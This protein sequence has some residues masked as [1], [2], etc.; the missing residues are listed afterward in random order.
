MI[1][2]NGAGRRHCR[3]ALPV[4]KCFI[5]AP[6]LCFA[7]L[8]AIATLATAA[9]DTPWIAFFGDY[10]RREGQ[11]P[12][13]PTACCSAP[14]CWRCGAAS[15]WTGS[16]TCCC[17]RLPCCYVYAVMQRCNWAF[18]SKP[19]ACWSAPPARVP[20]APS[21]SVGLPGFAF[22]V[23]HSAH[24]GAGA[25]AGASA[26]ARGAAAQEVCQLV[27]GLNLCQLLEHE[28]FYRDPVAKPRPGTSVSPSPW[29]CSCC[30]WVPGG[31]PAADRR[32]AGRGTGARRRPPTAISLVPA[33]VRGRG[34]ALAA[35]CF[36]AEAVQAGSRPGIWQASN[37]LCTRMRWHQ[38]AG[39]G[40]KFSAS[41]SFRA[42][43]RRP[44][45]ARNGF[46]QT[47]DRMHSQ[48]SK[49]F[50][51]AGI[52]A[53][54]CRS[55][56]RDGRRQSGPRGGLLPA[57]AAAVPARLARCPQP[58]RGMAVGA[59]VAAGTGGA[60][61]RA[62]GAE[63]GLA[64]AWIVFLLAMLPA[65]PTVAVACPAAA[66]SAPKDRTADRPGERT[67]RLVGGNP[68]RCA[69][70]CNPFGDRGLRGADRV[71][72]RTLMSG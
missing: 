70:H 59:V 38:C 22:A 21:A 3:A 34:N 5:S 69:H 52:L 67:D 40:R 15:S 47:I 13:S 41:F 57:P 49:Y 8:M 29:P 12:G 62:V 33:L 6:V 48:F 36:P 64:A 42:R 27:R 31:I 61:L 32:R 56:K 39:L 63:H 17:S 25:G 58:R 51:P 23:D 50:G 45:S 28:D 46:S 7:G 60:P 72:A 19:V 65:P 2:P 20:A 68:G 37:V 1:G 43:F 16:S 4:A 54:R 18:S 26:T 71:L 14:C 66:L 9:S 24:R 35:V 10:F 30:W 55:E 44:S 11:L 53:W